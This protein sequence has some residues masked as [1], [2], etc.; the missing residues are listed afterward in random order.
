MKKKEYQIKNRTSK[1][2]VE[3]PGITVP[4][5][6]LIIMISLLFFMMIFESVIAMTDPYLIMLKDDYWNS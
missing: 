6:A 4:Q 3:E 5:K 1:G 2:F